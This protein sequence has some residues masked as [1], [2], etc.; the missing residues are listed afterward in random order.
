MG[1]YIMYSPLWF[2]TSPKGICRFYRTQSSVHHGLYRLLNQL[3][4]MV[5]RCDGASISKDV[6]VGSP[7]IIV[8]CVLILGCSIL[9][10]AVTDNECDLKRL[11]TEQVQKVMVDFS[12]ASIFVWILGC[13]RI[14]TV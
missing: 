5:T 12:Q 7:R 13:S 3:V 10:V 4:T 1:Y 14:W 11:H 2:W 6:I 9:L 8:F